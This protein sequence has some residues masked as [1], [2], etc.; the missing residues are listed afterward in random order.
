VSTVT[1]AQR[2]ALVRVIRDAAITSS[3]AS[4]GH[5]AGGIADAALAHLHEVGLLNEDA[6]PGASDSRALKDALAALVGAIALYGGDDGHEALR[7]W[8]ETTPNA[9][10]LDAAGVPAPAAREGGER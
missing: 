3:F 5:K 6:G 4:W 2:A 10:L 9:V 8:L 1:N 7:H